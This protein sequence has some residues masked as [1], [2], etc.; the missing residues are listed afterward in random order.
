M[1]VDTCPKCGALITP[2]LARCRQCKAYLHGTKLEGFIFES[3]LPKNLAGSPGTGI[4][5]LI[6]VLYYLMMGLLAGPTSLIA[7]SGYSLDQFGN[8]SPAGIFLGEYWRFVTSMFGHHDLMHIAFNMYALTIVGPLVEEAFD[9]KKMM[10]IYFIGGIASMI[11]SYI[12]HTEWMGGRGGGSMGASGAVS[13]L[14]GATLFAAIR[15]GPEGRVVKAVM[16]RWTIYMAAFGLLVSGIDNAAHG[17]GFLTGAAL[18][19]VMP[20]G[21][22][23]TVTAQKLMSVLMLG[24]VALTIG[25]TALML[26]NLRGFPAALD[27]DGY[28]RRIFMF[29][30]QDPY[31]WSYSDQVESYQRCVEGVRTGETGEKAIHACELA[32]RALPY[33]AGAPGAEAAW[34]FRLLS[35]LL[36][37]DGQMDRARRMKYAALRLENRL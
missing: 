7:M 14:I 21:G 36:A 18:A 28:G 25:S 33:A 34:H 15:K 31:E 11:I 16:I 2:N 9:R 37:K 32:V 1:A 3:L 17:G 24:L 23:K 20:L 27:K 22:S 12:V 8:T 13:A 19:Y 5:F 29:E 26:D 6:V 35:V 4:I 30:V 10:V